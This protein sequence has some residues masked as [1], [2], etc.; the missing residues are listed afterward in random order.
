M[1]MRKKEFSPEQLQ[2]FSAAIIKKL[3]RHPVFLHARTILLYHSLPDE[4]CTHPLL[5]RWA[6]KKL[7]LLP[8]IKG[9]GE[10]ELRPYDKGTEMQ[11]NE[12][13]IAEP[14]GT[15]FTS[16]EKIDVAIIPGMAFNNKGQRLGRGKGFY[17]RLLHKLKSLHVHTIGI[18]FDFQKTDFIPTESHDV[19]VNEVL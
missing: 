11:K 2:A 18:C 6:G 14:T 3:E 4:V 10:L 13:G 5:Q 15:A 8:F 12:Y 1:R 7:I 19:S 17:D 16:Y 9:P